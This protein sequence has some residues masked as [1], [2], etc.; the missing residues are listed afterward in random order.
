M[1]VYGTNRAMCLKSSAF[2]LHSFKE[3]GNRAQRLHIGLVVG[4]EN[5]V[6]GFRRRLLET[7]RF[8]SIHI[9]HAAAGAYF[10]RAY[11]ADTQVDMPCPRLIGQ[12]KRQ[13]EDGAND[14]E[15]REDTGQV[16]FLILLALTKREKR[17]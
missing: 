15:G 1:K 5:G 4:V 17:P 11:L 7:T 10:S 16:S 14:Q 2:C 8:C 9:E 12:Q 3:L 6:N 13:K